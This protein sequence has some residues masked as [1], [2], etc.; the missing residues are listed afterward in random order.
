M[1]ERPYTILS[2]ALSIDGYLDDA[3]ERRL[4]L[5]CA[6]DLERVDA[7]RAQS[8]A[9]LVGAT[10]I[11]RDN[12]HLLVRAAALRRARAARALTP[13][14]LRVTLTGSANLAA[15]ANVFSAGDAETLVYCTH[16]AAA[17]AERHVGACAT[18]IDAGTAM[19][20]AWLATD[21]HRRG[22]RRLLVEG[23]NRVFTQFLLG[24]LVDE[25]QLAIAPVFVGDA[26]APRFVGSGRFQWRAGHRAR[27]VE[28]RMV[29]DVALLRYAL[30]ARG[31]RG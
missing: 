20:L 14:P 22:V 11:R 23:G 6:A 2:C 3:S 27:L 24:D 26:R 21:L 18:V 15:T 1:V 19:D 30:S 10:T 5:S 13:S 9:I 25:L 17:A 28:T 16:A 7:L 12:P 29:G 8:D 4:L 31:A